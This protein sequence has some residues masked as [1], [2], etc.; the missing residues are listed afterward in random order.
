VFSWPQVTSAYWL[1][2]ALWYSSLL[3]AISAAITSAQHTSIIDSMAPT[4]PERPLDIAEL[5]YMRKVILRFSDEAASDIE[6]N[7]FGETKPGFRARVML[8][9]WQCPMM[10]MAYSWVTFGLALTLFICTPFIT[11][12]PW[13]DGKKVCSA[14]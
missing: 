12:Q 2:R 4:S 8:Y 7:E 1:A 11:H 13:G 3:L 10:L 14:Q 5:H 6:R 9:I